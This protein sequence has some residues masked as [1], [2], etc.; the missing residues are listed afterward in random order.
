MTMAIKQKG[1]FKRSN[2]RIL[3]LIDQ[4]LKIVASFIEKLIKQQ[5]DI[6]S[7]VSF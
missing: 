2:C 7:E 3:K 6:C 1:M 4:I 5:V